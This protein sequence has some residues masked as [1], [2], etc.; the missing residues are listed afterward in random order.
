MESKIIIF[1]STN[2]EGI[3]STNKK[4]YPGK[5]EKYIENEFI[6]TRKKIANKFN[7]NYLKMFEPKQKM[8]D[9]D[10]YPDNKYVILDD[11]YMNKED[12]LDEIIH[13]DI[14]ILPS[15]YKEVVVGHRAADC[16]ILIL[17]DRKLG[18]TAL[19]HCNTVHINRELPM[20]LI[21][22]MIYEFN[23]KLNDLYLYISS[24]VHKENYIYDKYPI[25]A[26][27]EKIWHKAI[28]KE[29]DGYHIDIEKAILDQ[30]KIPNVN[31]KLKM[32]VKEAIEPRALYLEISISP[33]DTADN[34]KYASHTKA[35]Q[36]NK[37]KLGQNFIGFYY[38]KNEE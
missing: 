22:I 36:G 31:K 29:E 8:Q 4:F 27:N 34:N 20:N 2:E 21:K 11:S 15:K 6:K 24:F 35:V 33:I 14:L 9:N 26:T 28:T 37:E 5:S 13:T 25:W 18:L 38:K 12:F 30:I 23:C 17:E 7:F 10:D 16:P 32:R 3:F 1:E 19:C